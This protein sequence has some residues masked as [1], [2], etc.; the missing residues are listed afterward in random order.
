MSKP[1]TSEALTEARTVRSRAL[2]GIKRLDYL[3]KWRLSPRF[4]E[5]MMGLPAGW[6]TGVPGITLND[7]LKASGNGVVPQ[8]GSHALVLMLANQWRMTA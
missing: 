7:Q 3:D 6:I 2:S 5:W 1:R 8:Q 4:T